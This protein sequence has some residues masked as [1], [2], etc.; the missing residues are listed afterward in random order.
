VNVV[1]ERLEK[2]GVPVEG[3]MPAWARVFGVQFA[4]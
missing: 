1:R 4:F 3:L 2:R